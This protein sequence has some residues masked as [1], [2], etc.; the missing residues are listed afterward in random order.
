MANT[1]TNANLT[2]NLGPEKRIAYRIIDEQGNYVAQ[3]SKTSADM[4]VVDKIGNITG[5]NVQTVLQELNTKV[6][7]AG[8]VDDVVAGTRYGTGN[9]SLVA[10]DKVAYITPTAIGAAEQTAV[11]E[12][13]EKIPA[14][15]SK[16]NQLADK[17]YVGSTINGKLENYATKQELQD[18]LAGKAIAWVFNDYQSFINVV[19]NSPITDLKAG[20]NVY[21]RTL[22]VPDLWVSATPS[23]NKVTY[24]YT[25]DEAIVQALKTGTIQVG[26]FTFSALEANKVDL[27]DYQTKTDNTLNTTAKTVVGAINEIDTDV[28]DIVNGTTKVGAAT[29]ADD[30]AKL[31]NQNASYY[32]DYTN[33]SNTP[34]TY[35][36]H[37]DTVANKTTGV[38]YF[39][40]GASDA[41]DSR[42]SSTPFILTVSQPSSNIEYKS[43]VSGSSVFAYVKEGST[44]TGWVEYDL[45]TFA[46]KTDIPSKASDSDKLGGQLPAYYLNYN[47]STNKPKINTTNT[48]SQA[49]INKE[50][51]GTINLH[52][53]ASTGKFDDLVDS[54][55]HQTNTTGEDGLNNSIYAVPGL[56]LVPSNIEGMPLD[57][58]SGN[59]D[60][61]TAPDKVWLQ[62]TRAQESDNIGT[63]TFTQTIAY[64]QQLAVR[65]V[66]M[67]N[68]DAENLGST[69]AYGNWSLYNLDNFAKKTDIPTVPDITVATTG[70]GL[71]SGI[72]VDGTNKHKLNITKRELT[73]SDLPNSGATAGT[74]T[75]VTVNGKGVVTGGATL[76]NSDLPN[77]GATA[78]TYAKVTINNKGIVTAGASLTNADLPNS[79][80]AAGAYTA[81]EVN[82]KGV[83]TKGGTSIEFGTATNNT[84]SSNLIVGGLFFELQT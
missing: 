26:Y 80:V 84:P 71:V 24:T 83:V 81:V 25:N 36:S 2:D 11:D 31:N 73:S 60:M 51:S 77:S 21:I 55:V 10:D 29:S 50:I 47:N 35:I 75:K 30:A 22:N 69:V 65:S 46:K 5:D 7:S 23:G 34:I 52:K 37:I 28:K 41:P 53:I 45:S 66:I 54:P 15:A 61:M 68:N 16:T 1:T 49:T 33:L 19:N 40:Q 3:Y 48:T 12:I 56:Y 62:V 63:T 43:I 39:S 74:Y 70:S 9:K 4:V 67:T 76:V 42:F 6:G 17:T 72:A 59:N 57:I 14:A 13:N 20:D 78:G 18:G 32:L 27:S 58:T 38:Y 82:A 79:G 8:K 44:S 64:G